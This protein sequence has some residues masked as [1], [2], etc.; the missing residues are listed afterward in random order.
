MASTKLSPKNN[1]STPQSKPNPKRKSQSNHNSPQENNSPTTKV[2]TKLTSSPLKGGRSSRKQVSE[3]LKSPP[4]PRTNNTGMTLQVKQEKL[5]EADKATIYDSEG[6]DLYSEVKYKDPTKNPL[7]SSPPPES[8][9]SKK[10]TNTTGIVPV[11]ETQTQT[12]PSEHVTAP[13]DGSEMEI[14][15]SA[16]HE[17]PLTSEQDKSQIEETSTTDKNLESEFASEIET[18]ATDEQR[19]LGNIHEN[20]TTSAKTGGHETSNQGLKSCLKQGKYN[21]PGH[22]VQSSLSGAT[23]NT[24]RYTLNLEVTAEQKG[25][26]GL[27]G[28]YIDF[29][30]GLKEYRPELILLP[31]NTEVNKEKIKSPDKIPDTISK[32][33]VY[34]DGAKPKDSGDTV[35]AK[36]HFGFPVCFDRKTFESDVSDYIANTT[37]QF[38]VSPV[39]HHNVKVACWLPYLTRFCNKPLVS[40]IMTDWY[41][42]STKKDVSIGLSWRALNGQWDVPAKERIYAVHVECL[43]EH[44]TSVRKFL[45]NCSNQKRYPGGSRFR[46]MT[47]FWPCMTEKNKKKHRYMAQKHKYFLDQICDCINGQILEIDTKIPG[48][49]LTLRDVILS[50]RDNRDGHRIFNSIDIKWKSNTQ[51]ILTFRPDKKSMTYKFLNSLSTYV[52]HHYPGSDLS[53]IFTL[54]AIGRGNTEY[55]NAT[56]QSFTTMEDLATRRELQ[57][58]FDDSLDFLVL[59]DLQPLDMDEDD[60]DDQRPPLT[61]V[62]KRLWDLS[63]DADT[64]STMTA[65]THSVAFDDEATAKSL[66]SQPSTSTAKSKISASSYNTRLKQTEEAQKQTTN[67]IAMIKNNFDILMKHFGTTKNNLQPL[68]MTIKLRETI[69]HQGAPPGEIAT[70]PGDIYVNNNDLSGEVAPSVSHSN[71]SHPTYL[72]FTYY[73]PPKRTKKPA[74]TT[75]FQYL[76]KTFQIRYPPPT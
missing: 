3:V 32:L 50:I 22:K 40:Q 44:T 62:N 27:R 24:T 7:P 5:S 15:T 2:Q 20:D 36:I 38:Y 51:Y 6:E 71:V 11:T 48:T 28:V 72:P 47:E 9:K 34:F 1:N 42:N 14:T 49:R 23:M 65:D 25:T 64:A 55:Y 57:R 10:S 54:D 76:P 46:V 39:Q 4:K 29:F 58:D 19:Q 35:Y 43:Y 12:L 26:T 37:I 17:T 8:T 33:Q 16:T 52:V 31:W 66:A 67:D 18:E 53:R 56:T 68:I 41:K 30:K 63:G 59:Y 60:D 45:R 61:E 75:L 13:A 70:S 74:Q 69:S 21:S 73:A